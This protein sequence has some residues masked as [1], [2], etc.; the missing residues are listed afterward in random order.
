VERSYT[1]AANENRHFG[2]GFQEINYAFNTEMEI[3]AIH[4]FRIKWAF[5]WAR[6]STTRAIFARKGMKKRL[7]KDFA[8][9]KETSRKNKRTRSCSD[10]AEG[11]T[12]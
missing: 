2:F 3:H 8:S 5:D 10:E 12:R 1:I 7:I 11:V 6:Y 9:L 4:K